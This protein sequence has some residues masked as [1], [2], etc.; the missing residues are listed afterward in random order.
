MEQENVKAWVSL[1]RSLKPPLSVVCDGQKG[2]SKALKGEWPDVRVQR[3]H[4]HITRGMRTK[5]NIELRPYQQDAI[6]NIR[7]N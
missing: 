1:F 6:D 2:L 4:A 3:C 7:N 5:M